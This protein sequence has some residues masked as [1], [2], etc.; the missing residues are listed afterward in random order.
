MTQINFVD[1][2]TITGN[3]PSCSVSMYCK[4][5]T[6]SLLMPCN[7]LQNTCG[8][9]MKADTDYQVKVQVCV[10]IMPGNQP[11]AGLFELF[12]RLCHPIVVQ[13][14]LLK[15]GYLEDFMLGFRKASVKIGR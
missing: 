13:F 4:L 14:S 1:K 15:R 7:F 10:T 8:T 3:K 5:T 11:V 2:L 12:W 6:S 9:G